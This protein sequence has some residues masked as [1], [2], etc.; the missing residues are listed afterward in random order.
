LPEALLRQMKIGGRLIAFVGE[1]P[2]MEARRVRRM[3]EDAFSGENLFE[4]VAAPLT[5][6]SRANRFVF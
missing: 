5:N 1:A 6:A 3:S 2:S 4:T